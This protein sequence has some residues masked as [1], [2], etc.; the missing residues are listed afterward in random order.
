M[1]DV[2]SRKERDDPLCLLHGLAVDDEGLLEGNLYFGPL[3]LDGEQ[4][5]LGSGNSAYYVQPRY[6]DVQC[7]WLFSPTQAV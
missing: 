7:A 3:Q 1:M 5:G 6:V 2:S 4:P